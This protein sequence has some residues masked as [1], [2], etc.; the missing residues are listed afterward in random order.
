[1]LSFLI[2]ESSG[3]KLYIFL[4]K[5][6]LDAKYVGDIMPRA[7]DGEVIS[8]AERENRIL[9]TNDKDFGELIFRLKHPSSG[10]IL[11]RLKN[12]SPQQRQKYINL[13]I[14]YLSDKLK[15]NFIVVT[16]GQIRMRRLT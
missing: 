11:L 1:M 3:R 9:I 2:D 8:F 7:S 10:V 15:S 5:K 14:N 12:D 4:N 13:V 6:G 16:E